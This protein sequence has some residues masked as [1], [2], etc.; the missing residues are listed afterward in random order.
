MIYEWW[1]PW[2]RERNK[3]DLLLVLPLLSQLL[4]SGGGHSVASTLVHITL[5][6]IT[7]PASM[8]KEWIE[9]TGKH[10]RVQATTSIMDQ[11]RHKQQAI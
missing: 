8:G 1:R 4:L 7:L 6:Y 11:T 2:G 10:V 3:V 9:A 5:L